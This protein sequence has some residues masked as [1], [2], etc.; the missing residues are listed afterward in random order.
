[1]RLFTL[2][3]A[4]C[5]TGSSWAASVPAELFSPLVASK[6]LQ[7][8]QNVPNPVQYPQYTDRSQ[9]VWQYFPADYW[10]TGFLPASYYALH[11]RFASLCPN[12][13]AAQQFLDLGRSLSAPEVALEQH[14][15]VGHDVGFLSFPFVQELAVDSSNQTAVT[16]VN[17]FATLL[18]DRF[19]PIVGCTRSWD[20]SDP[21]DFQVIIDNMMNLQ[22]LFD[23]MALTGNTTLRDI[24]M[25]HAD[26][27]A[28]NHIRPD[29]SSYHV[30]EYNSTTGDVIRRRTAQ[31]YADNST[32]TRGQAWGIYG[33]ANMYRNTNESRYIETARRM[34][35]FYLS[36]VPSDGIVPWDFDAPLDPP[37]PADSSAAMIATVGLLMLS[38]QE[39]SLS[40]SNTTGAQY[41]SNAAIKL[42][43]DN[44]AF[45]WKP[46]WQSLLSNGTVNNP[47]SPPNNLT[48]IIYGDYYF[49]EAGN[50]LISMGL[51]SCS[52]NSTSPASPSSSI[53][54]GQQHTSG[55][56]RTRRMWLL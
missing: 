32:W 35:S 55:A 13:S 53:Q 33:F 49:V 15:T 30:V 23:S 11:T 2:V 14:T 56:P 37:R 20:T 28:Q 51:A 46:E 9:G 25:S 43:S 4:A 3:A 39:A 24:A 44:T 16:A 34:A 12:S 8:A 21:T 6:F 47:A 40:P 29:G 10:T 22:V 48:G 45:A 31:G 26:K 27:T 5:L 19:N 42:L 7:T 36:Q 54:P 17:T 52:G 50:Q 38:Q 1:M 41:W 18:A